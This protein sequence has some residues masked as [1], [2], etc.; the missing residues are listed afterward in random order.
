MTLET[1]PWPDCPRCQSRHVRKGHARE[2]VMRARTNIPETYKTLSVDFMNRTIT[3]DGR[4]IG[5]IT[6]PGID[7]PLPS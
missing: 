6:T 7:I 3:I 2:A 1:G 5:P 4:K